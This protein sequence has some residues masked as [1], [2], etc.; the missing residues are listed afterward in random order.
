VHNV[1]S[2]SSTDWYGLHL[3]CLSFWPYSLLQH[4]NLANHIAASSDVTD[5]IDH[6]TVVAHID[7]HH[8]DDNDDE[9]DGNNL[10][11]DIGEVM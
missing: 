6:E 10:M 3:A 8:D 11:R 7:G 4:T 9:S 2:F 1:I 5:D